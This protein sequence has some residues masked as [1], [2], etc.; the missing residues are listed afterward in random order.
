MARNFLT[1]INLNKNELQNAVVQNLGSAPTSPVKGQLYMDTGVNKLFWWDGTQW[2]AAMDA[3]ASTVYNQ[4]IRVN[5]APMTQRNAINFINTAG[6]NMGTADDAA[7]NETEV[8]PTLNWSGSV[9]PSSTF[10]QASAVG[11]S[12]VAARSD[13][14]HGTPTHDAAAHSA[15]PISALAAATADINMGTFKVTN[16]GPPIGNSDAATKNY[17]DNAIGGL[18]WKE[19]VRAATTT[20]G[21]LATAFAAGQTI[22]G[23]T[24]STNDRILLKNQTTATENGIWIVTAGA[25]TRATDADQ[26][27]DLEG[28]AVFVQQG[29]TL[30]DTAWVCTTD[31][32]ITPGSTATTWAQ[33]VGGGTVTAGAGM[34]QSGNTLNVIAGDTSLT[35]AADDIRVNTAVIASA[36]RQVIAGAGL[37][38]GGD[39]TADR[40]LNVVAANGSIVVG[41]DDVQVGFLTANSINGT[42]VTAARSDHTHTGTYARVATAAVTATTSMAVLHNFG[43]LNVVVNVWRTAS[44][45]DTIECDVERTNVNTVTVRFAVAP[46]A[47]EY[48]VTVIG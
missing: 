11:T 8:F 22:D 33:F 29:T 18:S 47:S 30:G 35:V 21:T 45:F 20:N 44:P 34:T 10:G 17:V 42:A 12:T 24:L 36:T 26:Q 23:V 14:V 39:L 28:A 41:A 25:P 6:I 3:G 13:H 31:G 38:G 5:N 37:T 27:G 46:A 9:T 15:I 2:V 32:S 4:L 40:T 19:A 16:L 43:T 7:N 1:P 48:T